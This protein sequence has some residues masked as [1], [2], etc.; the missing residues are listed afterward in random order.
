M[1]LRQISENL[2]M[3][4]LRDE[5][6]SRGYFNKP[7]LHTD[8]QYQAN[9]GHDSSSRIAGNTSMAI[10]VPKKPRHRKFLGIANRY[11]TIRL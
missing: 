4:K 3:H 11:G 6:Q 9:S 10:G 8:Q 7:M 2:L 5:L 1:K